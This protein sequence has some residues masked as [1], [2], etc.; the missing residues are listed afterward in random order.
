MD[1][2]HYWNTI[3]VFPVPGQQFSTHWNCYRNLPTE[4]GG[5]RRIIIS[6]PPEEISSNFPS[7]ETVKSEELVKLNI[8][9]ATY[10][11]IR[12]A[13]GVGIGRVT[14]KAFITNRPADGYK[15]F[16]ELKSLNKNLVNINWEEVE[17]KLAFS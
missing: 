10:S 17:T 8:N 14:P 12:E 2:K 7:L 5:S 11:S 16:D 6:I 3:E 13:L 15:D 4:D 1:A 9:I